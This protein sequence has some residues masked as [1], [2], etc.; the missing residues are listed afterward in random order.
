MKN[1]I[2]TLNENLISFINILEIVRKKKIKRFIYASSSSVYGETKI[3]PFN[4][5]DTKN[6]PISVYGASKLS[7]EI[8][9]QSYSRNFKIK[10]FGLRFFTVYGPYGRPDMAYFSFI[11]KL[12]NNKKIK[13]FNQ[14]IMK[15]DFTFIDDVVQGIVDVSKFK[16]NANHLILNIGKGKP[17]NLMD[18]I[19]IIQKNFKKKFKIDFTKNIP[20]GD[21]K[22][23]FSNTSKAKKLI[24]WKPKTSLAVGLKKFVNW[25][26]AEYGS[27]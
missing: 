5:N 10:C 16:T 25:Y 15:R 19:K 14:G 7:N 3:Y 18:L 8:I 26:T 12:K 1:P 21:I 4:E 23:T 22:K 24:G 13:V 11:E 9:A 20:P 17:D 27:K 6:V 2:N